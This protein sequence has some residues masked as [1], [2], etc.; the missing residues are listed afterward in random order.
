MAN[1]CSIFVRIKLHVQIHSNFEHNIK[2]CS[3]LIN[4]DLRSP[5]DIIFIEHLELEHLYFVYP[6]EK[7]YQIDENITNKSCQFF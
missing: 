1:I 4:E 7:L 6:G 3:A 5:K 2:I